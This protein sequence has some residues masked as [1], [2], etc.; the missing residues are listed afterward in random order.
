MTPAIIHDQHQKCGPSR[1]GQSRGGRSIHISAADD[2]PQDR[3]ARCPAG[4]TDLLH[5]LDGAARQLC[6]VFFH[7]HCS[8]G[9]LDGE[10]MRG[11]LLPRTPRKRPIDPIMQRGTVGRAIHSHSQ[12]DHFPCRDADLHELHSKHLSSAAVSMSGIGT[13]QLLHLRAGRAKSCDVSLFARLRMA[14]L[15]LCASKVR[16]LQHKIAI[17]EAT[18]DDTNSDLADRLRAIAAEI[19]AKK[20][21]VNRA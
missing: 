4:L 8:R 20:A 1:D 21:G 16:T 10:H 12:I 19:E 7:S 18:G 15:D 3:R 14:Y 9:P 11:R 6:P 17:E 5:K 2:Q 13:N